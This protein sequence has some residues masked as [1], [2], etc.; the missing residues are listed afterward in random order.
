MF[1]YGTDVMLGVRPP[2]ARPVNRPVA[3]PAPTPPRPSDPSVAAPLVVE[4][5][6]RVIDDAI[7]EATR[8]VLA[9]SHEPGCWRD[10]L[11]AGLHALLEVLEND[12]DFAW[13]W[14]SVL[15]TLKDPAVKRRLAEVDAKLVAAIAAA[16][17]D[18]EAQSPSADAAAWALEAARDVVEARLA[19][20]DRPRLTDLTE[21]LTALIA[22]PFLSL[23][24]VT[25]E[26]A[27]VPLS[28]RRPLAARP[29]GV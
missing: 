8:A 17:D 25:Q 9:A 6:A 11:R 2:T 26:L 16:A 24:A 13:D 23:E 18:G 15:P 27:R 12:P 14:I 4:T 28:P 22:L 21:G 10:R 20:E 19:S 3:A 29:A 7:A 1:F 5:Y